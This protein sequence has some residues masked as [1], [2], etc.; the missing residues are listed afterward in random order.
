MKTII[1]GK[2]SLLSKYLCLK[3]K[4]NIVFSARGHASISS[5]VK[6]IKNSKKVNLILNNFFP[7]NKISDITEKEYEKF[8]D[9]SILF[10]AKLFSKLDGKNINKII[11]SSSSSVYNSIRK[12]YQ[13]KDTNNK[14]LYSSTKI[15]AENL[16]YNFA[17]KNNIPFLILRIFNMYSEKDDK[18]SI[19]SKLLKSINRSNEIKLYNG[20]ENIR[21]FIH[22]KDVVKLINYFIKKKI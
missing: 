16:I 2:Q 10:N 9:Q 3:N 12:D 14:S 5:I 1:L 8:Y 4:K 20:G 18:F 7:S 17:S 19:V 21:D 15:A 11:Y 13:F 22:V 6:E